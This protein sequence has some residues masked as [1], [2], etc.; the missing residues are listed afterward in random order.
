MKQIGFQTLHVATQSNKIESLVQ[1][2][3]FH[4]C[5]IK[6]CVC[7]L[8]HIWIPKSLIL[9]NRFTTVFILPLVILTDSHWHVLDT[10]LNRPAMFRVK[11]PTASKVEV[12][13]T[14]QSYALYTRSLT[15]VSEYSV[16]QNVLRCFLNQ[17]CCF[18]QLLFRLFNCN[19]Y[20]N[21]VETRKH[22]GE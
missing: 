13:H 12:L 21:T 2:Y 8:H 19:H 15:S 4:N 17:R 1:S 11:N 7:A 6:K 18:F 16:L 3:Y 10:S 5:Q 9:L 14:P 20:S 22:M